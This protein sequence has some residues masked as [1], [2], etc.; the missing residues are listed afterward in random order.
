MHSA[1][2]SGWA[3][4]GAGRAAPSPQVTNP[5]TGRWQVGLASGHPAITDFSALRRTLP[6]GQGCGR[7]PP[8]G[9]GNPWAPRHPA[10]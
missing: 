7:K 9:C 6:S 4:Q 3:P 1:G 5:H 2:W 10:G 8:G